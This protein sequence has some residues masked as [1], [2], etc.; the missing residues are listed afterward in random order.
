MTANQYRAALAKLGWS[1]EGAAQFLGISKRTSQNYAIDGTKVAEPVAILL[2]LL[3]AG[4]IAPADLTAPIQ[5][6]HTRP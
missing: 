1:Q 3:L 6:R 5:Y 4:K 2:R